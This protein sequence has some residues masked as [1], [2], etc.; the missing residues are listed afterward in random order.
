[1]SFSRETG[2]Q[3]H[4]APL[5]PG[6]LNTVKYV[7]RFVSLLNWVSYYTLLFEVSD[8]QIVGLLFRGAETHEQNLEMSHLYFYPMLK[9]FFVF[10][11]MR[12]KDLNDGQCTSIAE[13]T[14]RNAKYVSGC[15]STSTS[16]VLEL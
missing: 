7:R 15:C 4:V 11:S 5:L 13:K 10:H 6:H 9:S 14:S 1:M 12:Q 8:L 16:M 2:N 3:P